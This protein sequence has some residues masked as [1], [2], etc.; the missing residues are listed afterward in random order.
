[1]RRRLDGGVNDPLRRLVKRLL[2]ALVALFALCALA[3]HAQTGESGSIDKA[4][5]LQGVSEWM[6]S[7]FSESEMKTYR[8]EDFRVDSQLCNCSDQPVPHFPYVLVFFSTPKGDLVGRPERRGFDT[9]ITPLAVRH[10]NRYCE[11]DAEDE[12]FGAFEH[13]C[14]FSDFRYG[15]QL[16]PYFPYCKASVPQPD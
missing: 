6:A 13:P 4:F 10:G 16:A 8:P 7:K 9:I 15:Q 1:M 14:D 3:A 5:G 11:L 12:C 2:E